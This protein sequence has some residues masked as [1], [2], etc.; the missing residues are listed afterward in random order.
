MI[1]TKIKAKEKLHVDKR[2]QI[3]DRMN[4]LGLGISQRLQTISCFWYFFLYFLSVL[5]AHFKPFFK[6]SET[7]ISKQFCLK[8]HFCFR[9]HAQKFLETC[10]N[11]VLK[12]QPFFLYLSSKDLPDFR[13]R[14]TNI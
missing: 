5:K 14:D 13:P 8:F 6:D 3:F 12:L 10:V 1:K 11:C 4:C 9:F 7:L 2:P